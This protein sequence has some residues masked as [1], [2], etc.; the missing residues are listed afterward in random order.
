M[1]EFKE[2][3][4]DFKYKG[5]SFRVTYPTVERSLRFSEEFAK[6]DRPADF[7]LDFLDEHGLPKDKALKLQDEHIFEIVQY[8]TGRKKK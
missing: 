7:V 8:I 2:K 3:V 1:V 4:F 6:S 5:D